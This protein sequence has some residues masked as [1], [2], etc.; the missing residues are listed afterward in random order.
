MGSVSDD[1]VCPACGAVGMGGYAPD[2]VGR[3]ICTNSPDSCL[4]K[5]L[6]GRLQ[7]NEIRAMIRQRAPRKAK[8]K[9]RSN[10]CGRKGEGRSLVRGSAKAKAK[11]GKAHQ[12][13]QTAV[14]ACLSAWMGRACMPACVRALFPASLPAATAIPSESQSLSA[15][16]GGSPAAS[17]S[18]SCTSSGSQSLS[19]DFGG[20][21]AASESP[22]PQIP[23]SRSEE[24]PSP[25]ST[26]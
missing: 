23:Q 3:P 14:R 1:Y 4:S 6:D 24:N 9:G 12:K 18:H 21:P 19:A 2:S 16:F 15:G 11:G 7:A 20:S 22:S 10:C 13:G 17:E 26:A 8:G 5:L 25:R